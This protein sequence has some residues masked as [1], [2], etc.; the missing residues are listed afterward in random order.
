MTTIPQYQHEAAFPREAVKRE[1]MNAARDILLPTQWGLTKLEYAAVQI[2]AGI[3]ACSGS[4][5]GGNDADELAS[6]AVLIAKAV[7]DKTQSN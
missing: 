7:L 3:C 2:A 1:G 5:P 4:W 6:R